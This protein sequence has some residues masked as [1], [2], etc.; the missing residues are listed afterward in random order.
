MMVGPAPPSYTVSMQHHYK[1]NVWNQPTA[2]V[3]RGV[4]NAGGSVRMVESNHS[5]VHN[6]SLVRV[7]S[8][9]ENNEETRLDEVEETEEGGEGEDGSPSPPPPYDDNQK[10]NDQADS[11]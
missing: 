2:V 3:A 10:T 5:H 11:H 7:L 8:G 6:V 9:A 4:G 1:Y